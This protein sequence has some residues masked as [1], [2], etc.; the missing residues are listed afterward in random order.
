MDY[1]NRI[2]FLQP[3][4]INPESAPRR[5]KKVW[6][7]FIIIFLTCFSIGYIAKQHNLNRWPQEANNY[8]PITLKPKKVG[9]FQ[10]VKNFVFHSDNLLIGQEEDRINILLLGMGGPGHDGPYLTDTNI[11]LSIQPSTKQ[12]AMISVPR[13]LGVEIGGAI[14]KINYA[15]AYGEVNSPGNGGEYARQIFAKTF[16][17]DIPYYIRVDF[18]A[19]EDLINEVGGISID[20]VHP[21]TDSQ[22]PGPNYSYQTIT[23]TAGIQT[24]DGERAL[25]YARSRHGNNGEGSDFARAR[26]Q[27][28]ILSAL[29][30]KLLSFGT[31]TNPIRIQKILQTLSEHITTNL[32]FGQI[33]YLANLGREA[34]EGI[35]MLV[36]DNGT[37]GFLNSTITQSGAFI[38]YPRAGDFNEINTAIKNIFNDEKITTTNPNPIE[39]PSIFPTAKIEIQNGTWIPGLAALVEK[40]LQDKGF[41]ILAISNSAKRPWDKTYIYVLNNKIS[42][43]ITKIIATE[44][45]AEIKTG[46]PEWLPL[47]S[48][49]TAENDNIGYNK[50]ADIII[51]LGTDT[52]Q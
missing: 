3:Q 17:L 30:E 33:M 22:F 36:L 11:I 8:D 41:T 10:A 35:K 32:D 49:T 48:S 20:V 27:Q 43:E 52:K 24:M 6:L 25:Q 4:P 28:Q 40:K 39:N 37:N 50:D 15:N 29:K 5:P 16:N 45:N 18:K 42:P 13:D 51:V 26:R 9:I 12:I 14:R 21:F 34:N 2:N 7:F 19:F 31:Y 47:I 46:L 44:L 38:L 23:F 1:N